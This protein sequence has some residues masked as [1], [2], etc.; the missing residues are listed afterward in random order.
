MPIYEYACPRCGAT[1]SVLLRAGEVEPRKCAECGSRRLQRVISRCNVVGAGGGP[2]R[3][4][5][6]QWLERPESF[7]AAMKDFQAR[8]GTKLP[9]DRVDDAMHRLSEAGKKA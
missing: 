7:G 8:T 9:S 2:P 1:L 3:S 4:Q 6:R 5:A